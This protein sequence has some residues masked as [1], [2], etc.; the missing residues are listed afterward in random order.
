MIENID[1]KGTDPTKRASVLKGLKSLHLIGWYIVV[2]IFLSFVL[3]SRLPIDAVVHILKS[4][5][6]FYF[7]YA[8]FLLVNRFSKDPQIGN[9]GGIKWVNWAIPMI[10]LCIALFLFAYVLNAGMLLNPTALEPHWGALVRFFA[11]HVDYISIVPIFLYAIANLIY[12]RIHPN[13]DVKKM[14]LKFFNISD[15]PCVVPLVVVILIAVMNGTASAED[16]LFFSGA[17]AMLI[18]SSNILTEIAEDM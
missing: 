15:F 7:S 2:I 5:S 9:S 17:V 16:R 11:N 10:T 8:G 3:S 18:V 6:L 1:P 14:S 4:I 13:E 12:S